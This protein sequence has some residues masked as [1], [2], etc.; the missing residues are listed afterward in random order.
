[1]WRSY[2]HW[3]T[4]KFLL[5]MRCEWQGGE[6]FLPLPGP[7]CEYC[8]LRFVVKDILKMT[9]NSIVPFCMRIVIQIAKKHICM[10]TCQ[11]DSTCPYLKF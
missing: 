10:C 4:Q 2:F 9:G 1:M 3:K 11:K 7:P 6:Y 8:R 5:D